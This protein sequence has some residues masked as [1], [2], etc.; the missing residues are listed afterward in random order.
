MPHCPYCKE[1]VADLPAHW[2]HCLEMMR[3][4]VEERQYQSPV[5]RPYIFCPHCGQKLYS[6]VGWPKNLGGAWECGC[7]TQFLV[8]FLDERGESV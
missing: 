5:T 2:A 7:G 1:D 3:A 6:Y 4:G 8:Y